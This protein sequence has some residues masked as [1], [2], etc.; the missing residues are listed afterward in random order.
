MRPY[1]SAF[2]ILLSAPCAAQERTGQPLPTGQRLTPTAAPGAR[3]EP[4]VARTGPD[5]AYVV[6]G[7]AAI[8]RRPDGREM[9]VLTSGF[10]RFNGPDGKVVAAQSVQYIFRYAIDGHGS[11]RVQTLTVPNSYGGIAW[12]PD[13]RGFVVGG[14]V[15]DNVHV[16]GWSGGRYVETATIRLGHAAGL[17]AGVK[18]QA[19]GVAVSPDGHYGLV[20][21]YYNDSVSLLD[22]D[23]G[24]VIA[25]Q[26]LRPGKIDPAQSGVPGGEFPFAI[27]WT[28]AGHAWVSSPRDRQIVAL[29]PTR[30][31]IRITGRIATIGEPTALLADARTHRL[32]ATEDNGDRLAVI[33]TVQARLV[34]EP[35][36]TLP[37][38]LAAPAIGKGL[39]PNGLAQLRDGRLLVTLG[40]INA[41]A[42]VA[43]SATG[44]T[45]TGLVPTGWYPSAV[46][47]SADGKRVFVVNRKSPPGP[48]PQGCA[49]KLAIYRGQPNACGAANQYIYQL[50]KAGMLEF[51]LPD[52][53]ALAA[54]TLQVADN[55]GLPGAAARA[56][57]EANMA[58][59]RARVSHVVFIIKEN[60]TYDQVL[61]DLE[62]GNGDPHLAILGRALSPNHHRL[63]RQFAT[64]DNF[65]DSGEQ[66]S[67]GWTWST[68][69]RT[70]DLLEKTAPVN[71]AQRGLAY[72]AEE[73]DRFVYA[74]Q[75]PAERQ[76]TNPALSKDPDLL[77]GPALLTAPDGDDDDDRNQGFLWDQAIRAGL[78]VRNYGFSDASV[79]DAGAPGAIPVI[80][81]P[82]KTGTR[83]YTPGDR[84]LAKRSDPYFRG[85]DQKLPDY[86]RMLEWRREFDA[87]DAAGKVPALTLLRLSHDHF[88]DFKEAIDGVN[89]VETEMADNDYALGMV[90][91]A[92]A[93]SRVAGSTLV[94]VIE[95]DA[96]NGADHVDA[97]RSFAF[98]AG[99]YVRQGVVVSTRYTTV[100]VLRT[101]E[102]VL[103]LKPLGLNDGLAAPMAD[104]FDPAQT[105][106]TYR[107][108]AADVLRTTQLPIPAD[109]FAPRIAATTGRCDHPNSAWWAVAMRG[110]DFRTEDHL[111]TVAFNA[112]L[113]RGLGSGVQPT[114][115][116]G[117]NLRTARSELIGKA[118]A[119]CPR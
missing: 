119:G 27:A 102:A 47:T 111:D 71:Y 12:R 56:A 40:G 1:L 43:P 116:D 44:G 54:T 30:S 63:A 3:F 109:R 32:F 98:V 67:T 26:D 6:D 50:E 38:A 24:T 15:D 94:F 107:A 89:T 118:G 39:N 75:T 8:A 105:H 100:N 113:W 87:A 99:P 88:G 106:W 110:Q 77:A 28:D 36:L 37:D 5:P 34:A 86:W 80:R 85:F 13:G 93:N 62:V 22:L 83:I 78:S 58:A 97:R 11:R 95:D 7:A 31:G 18:P 33:D 4:L 65:Y 81:E 117:R 61:G 10:N 20:A 69:A 96:Q 104:L 46:A 73:A 64:L 35:R 74:Q 25:E 9:L 72:E 2:A 42:I 76:A 82:W 60:R 79:Y 103:G 17:G 45:V 101:I 84:L 29:T 41:V 53:K 66:S 92:I 51:P 59:I 90:V 21:N 108:D 112:A 14:G 91:E 16:F 114:E 23:R 48:N 115:R 68:A 49:P 55:I 52:D 57:A 19:A 70:P